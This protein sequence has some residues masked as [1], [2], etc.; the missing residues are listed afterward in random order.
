[1]QDFTARLN[2]VQHAF[3]PTPDTPTLIGNQADDTH[4]TLIMAFAWIDILRTLPSRVHQ[5]QLALAPSMY[6]QF[7][8]ST[9]ELQ[10]HMRVAG[11][12]VR[13][14]STDK[15][16]SIQQLI[17]A[18]IDNA[19]EAVDAAVATTSYSVYR[20]NPDTRAISTWLQL[21]Q[22]QLKLW[23]NERPD[24]LRETITLT[25]LRK[26]YIAFRHR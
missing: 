10:Q 13:D 22:A 25:P 8:L 2:I 6:A 3:L 21:R 15:A 1:M 11:R 19:S 9:T 4:Q 18:A 5:D 20:D 14:E 7:N 12:D 17:H 16:N 26:W 23:K 24:L